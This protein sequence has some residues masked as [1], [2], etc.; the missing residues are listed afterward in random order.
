MVNIVKNEKKLNEKKL[1]EKKI[2]FFIY[3]NNYLIKIKLIILNIFNIFNI[4]NG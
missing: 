4:S 3:D 2:E 1:N